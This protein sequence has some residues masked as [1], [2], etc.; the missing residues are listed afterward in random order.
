MLSDSPKKF[1]SVVPFLPV[2]NLKATIDYYRDVLGFSNEWF[3]G[4]SDAT[5]LRDDMRLLFNHNPEY[6]AVVNSAH[7]NLEIMWFVENIDAIYAEY[8]EKKVN[9]VT[10][11]KNKPWGTREFT[12]LDMNGY[13]IRI[14]QGQPTE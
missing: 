6:A 12:I 8:T 4:D 9:I 3:W 1:N 7:A 2:A 13:Y 11:L 14:A 10:Q 5:I